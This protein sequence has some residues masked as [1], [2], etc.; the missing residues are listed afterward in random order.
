M[1]LWFKIITNKRYDKEKTEAYELGLNVG[2]E[3]RQQTRKMDES[4]MG[5]IMSGFNL[6]KALKEIIERKAP[7]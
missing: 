5:T 7:Y 6:D 3:V 4:H 2:D 1:K